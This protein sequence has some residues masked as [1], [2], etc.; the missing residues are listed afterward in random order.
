MFFHA[1][2][3]MQVVIA[4]KPFDILVPSLIC[5]IVSKHAEIR[6]SDGIFCKASKNLGGRRER[7]RTPTR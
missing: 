3:I 7:P 1:I 6:D 2:A 5:H 4:A